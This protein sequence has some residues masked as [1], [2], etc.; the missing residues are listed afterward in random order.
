MSY[1]VAVRPVVTSTVKMRFLSLS[2]EM[3]F[4]R[5]NDS[6]GPQGEKTGDVEAPSTPGVKITFNS[7]ASVKVVSGI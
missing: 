5:T 3:A 7:G 4:I 6:D 1:S 2:Y